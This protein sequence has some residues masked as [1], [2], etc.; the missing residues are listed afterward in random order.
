MLRLDAAGTNLLHKINPAY[1]LRNRASGP[2]CRP[3]NPRAVGRNDCR[4]RKQRAVLWVVLGLRKA[5]RVGG[6]HKVWLATFDEAIET[7]QGLRHRESIDVD[8]ENSDR[9][10]RIIE[11]D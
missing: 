4:S 7:R 8:P 11:H 6:D 2:A 5:A 10:L 9:F 1:A 3:E